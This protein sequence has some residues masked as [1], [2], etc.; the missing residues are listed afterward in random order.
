[1][2]F[3][4]NDWNKDNLIEILLL[5]DEKRMSKIFLLRDEGVKT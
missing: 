5:L 4:L 2:K 3:Y 1:M